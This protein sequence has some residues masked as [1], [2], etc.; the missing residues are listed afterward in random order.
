M[1]HQ[2]FPDTGCWDA[3]PR[4]MNDGSSDYNGRRESSCCFRDFEEPDVIMPSRWLCCCHREQEQLRRFGTWRGRGRGRRRVGIHMHGQFRLAHH[5]GR[6]HIEVPPG[7]AVQGNSTISTSFASFLP[8]IFSPLPP[9]HIEL[10][11]YI[12]EQ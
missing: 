10:D 2:Q 6:H 5:P 9:N 12:Q 7:M 1:V 3:V 8:S 11:Y 4:R